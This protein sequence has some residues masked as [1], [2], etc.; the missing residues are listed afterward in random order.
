MTFA[1]RVISSVLVF[2]LLS[3]GACAQDDGIPDDST[4][5]EALEAD[6]QI[7]ACLAEA[8][9]GGSLENADIRRLEDPQFNEAVEDCAAQL[10][11][12]IPAPGD[13]TRAMAELTRSV[14]E[15]LQ[16]RGWDVPEPVR[17]PHGALSTD[18]LGG[19]VPADLR[20]DFTADFEDCGNATPR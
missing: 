7:A 18:E 8:G 4:M 3:V 15:C 6:R 1:T 13:T 2:S 9:H 5:R 16:A 11:I 19:S 14:V 20:D 10:D 12:D 17:G